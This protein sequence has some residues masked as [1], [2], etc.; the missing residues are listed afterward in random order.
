MRR[1]LPQDR[2]GGGGSCCVYSAPGVILSHPDRRV[3]P[4]PSDAVPFPHESGGEAAGA[5]PARQAGGAPA[6]G[7]PAPSPLVVEVGP[8]GADVGFDRTV[9]LLQ[10]QQFTAALSRALTP[11]EVARA[12]VAASMRALEADAGVL[13]LLTRDGTGLEAVETVGLPTA[14]QGAWQR[15]P[16]SVEAPITRAVRL[17]E[18]LYLESRAARDAVFGST[19]ELPGFEAQASAPL[20]ANGRILGAWSLLFREPK[21]WHAEDRAFAAMLTELCGQALE[22][23]RLFDA[24]RQARRAAERAVGR[25]ARLQRVS[26]S[27][28]RAVTREEVARCCLEEGADALGAVTGMMAL[29]DPA[30]GA[31]H[32][33]HVVGAA[34]RHVDAAVALPL[35]TALPIC[36]AVREARPVFTATEREPQPQPLLDAV[37]RDAGADVFVALP[38]ISQGEVR[39]GIELALPRGRSLD[40]DER[41]FALTLASQCVQALE[42]ARLYAAERKARAVAEAASRAKSEFLAVMSH[43]LRTPLTT[44]IGYADLLL[45]EVWGTMGERQKEHLLHVKT[46]AWHL[47]TI[48]DDILAYSQVEA[49]RAEFRFGVVDVTALAAESLALFEPE[50]E[51]KG[52]LLRA[53][54]PPEGVG[55]ETD[56]GKLRQILLNLLGN[57]VKFTDRGEVALELEAGD[58]LRIRVR[59]TGPGIAAE[60]LERIFEPFTQADQSSTR[61]KGGIGLGLAV[62]RTLAHRLGGTLTVESAPGAGT[63]F[64]LS[65]PPSRSRA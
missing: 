14:F 27:L 23:A 48:I 11:A 17:R 43:E 59:D 4:L 34:R 44:V 6:H 21:P 35:S 22:R 46:S 64:H 61:A 7:G 52:L 50:A 38:L 32:V 12:A 37:R 45:S 31:L 15:I 62:S 36:V 29:L 47:V 65:L 58:P 18:P 20:I 55:A 30:D 5:R 9:R 56:A 40:A 25:A 57:A 42:R 41:A 1:K 53:L 28:A 16:L 24:E 3:T 51:Q 39:G 63:T 8:A 2:A 10:L 13:A 19:P 54:L 60:H 49:G 33:V 26:A